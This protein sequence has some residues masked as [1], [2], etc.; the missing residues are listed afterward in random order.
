MAPWHD[1]PSCPALDPN[2]AT[3]SDGGKLWTVRPLHEGR[4]ISLPET[5]GNLSTI[6]LACST[7][8]ECWRSRE[9]YLADSG[10]GML[11]LPGLV[12][13]SRAARALDNVG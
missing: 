7:N 4:W 11:V 6:A 3:T 13:Q 9:I 12:V 2:V 10:G 5:F 1:G 8:D